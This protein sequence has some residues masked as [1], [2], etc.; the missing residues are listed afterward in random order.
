[1]L[2]DI[3][4]SKRNIIKTVSKYMEVL[5][6]QKKRLRNLKLEIVETIAQIESLFHL[7]VLLAFGIEIDV[8]NK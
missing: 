2:S 7:V 8:S 6:D 4:L 1:M 5:P 3:F